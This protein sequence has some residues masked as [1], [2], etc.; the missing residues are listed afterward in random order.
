MRETGVGIVGCSVL[1]EAS[2]TDLPFRK[3]YVEATKEAF[4][5]YQRA[6]RELVAVEANL[7][8]HQW[9]GSSFVDVIVGAITRQSWMDSAFRRRLASSGRLPHVTV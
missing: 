9:G 6:T 7:T 3:L 5:Q 8:N 1:I 2:F 4:A